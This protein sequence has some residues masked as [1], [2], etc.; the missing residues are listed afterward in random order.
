[1][2]YIQLN[3]RLTPERMLA[4]MVGMTRVKSYKQGC[5]A[6]R[7]FSKNK[8]H[9]NPGFSAKYET[10]PEIDSPQSTLQAGDLRRFSMAALTT[11]WSV[12]SSTSFSNVWFRGRMVN[13]PASVDLTCPLING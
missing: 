11:R 3:I 4:W 2:G 7:V 8:P 12:C 1:M 10:F 9:G 5:R 6:C 13:S